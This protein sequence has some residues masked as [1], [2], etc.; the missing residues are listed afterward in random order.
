MENKE[1]IRDEKVKFEIKKNK[2]NNNEENKNVFLLDLFVCLFF[3]V[4]GSV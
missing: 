2:S 4:D 3:V 1:R